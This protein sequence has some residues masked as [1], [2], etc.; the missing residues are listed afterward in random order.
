MQRLGSAAWDGETF[1]RHKMA[2][3]DC[4]AAFHSYLV[5]SMNT[6]GEGNGTLLQYF[7]LENLMDGRLQSMGSLKVGY[8]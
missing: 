7:C 8:D 1:R 5:P 4:S 2:L 3:R 6:W